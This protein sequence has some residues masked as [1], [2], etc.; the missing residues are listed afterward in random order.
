ML[1]ILKLQ[2][3]RQNAMLIKI[4]W[5]FLS[6][7]LSEHYTRNFPHLSMAN[8]FNEHSVNINIHSILLKLVNTVLT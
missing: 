8:E 5:F 3:S 7:P 2:S 6:H 4:R 1:V